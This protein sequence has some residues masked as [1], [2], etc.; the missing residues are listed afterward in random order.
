MKS[1]I[2][3]QDEDNNLLDLI[4][5]SVDKKPK[6]IYILLGDVKE[7]GY[8]L[9]ENIILGIKSKIMLLIGIDKKNTTKSMLTNMLDVTKQ[10]YIYNNNQDIEFDSNMYIFEYD[11]N[12]IVYESSSSLSES[13]LLNNLS[14]IVK[15]EIDLDKN[16]DDFK[17]IVKNIKLLKEQK[18][19]LLTEEIIEKLLE[20]KQIFSNKQYIHNVKSI[21]E[22]LGKKQDQVI[23]KKEIN[24][25]ILGDVNIPKIELDKFDFDIDTSDVEDVIV[26]EN[27]NIKKDVKVKKEE[28]KIKKIKEKETKSNKK[29]NKI[30]EEEVTDLDSNEVFDLDS[31]LISKAKLKLSHSKNEDKIKEDNVIKTKKIDLNNISNYLFELY[32]KPK[33]GPD[34]DCIKI[35]NYIKDMIPG[36]FELN[37]NSKSEVINGDMYKVREI[38]IE[39]VDVLNKNKLIDFKAKMMHKQN[40]NYITFNST[41]F[42]DIEY[43]IKDIAR[44]IKLSSS[45]YHIEFV[46]QSLQ[47][48]KLWSKLNTQK[49]KGIDRKYGFM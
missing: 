40:Q 34:L 37:E 5:K 26:K 44:V 21:S 41:K 24:D 35:P 4:K 9:L 39:M 49:F 36:F 46:S 22:F 13:G 27:N 10:V 11:K 47:E 33:K 2:I 16:K 23:D 7:S 18:F 25:D 15:L 32:E 42:R 17:E 38:Q 30:N 45:V 48:Y 20:E 1:E 43:S 28:V 29:T 14:S 19:E 12:V 3:F 6:N 31:M 8:E